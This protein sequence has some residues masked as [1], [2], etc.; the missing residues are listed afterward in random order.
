MTPSWINEVIKKTEEKIISTACRVGDELIFSTYDDGKYVEHN[1]KDLGWWTN[2]FWPG[3]LWLIYRE[4]KD[5][6]I[7]AIAQSAGKKLDSVLYGYD[8]VDHDAGFMWQLSAVTEYNLTGND[9][10]RRKGLVAAALLASRYVGIGEYI[11]A[12]NEEERAG[13]AIVDCMMN[14]PLL[15]WASQ[16]V[17]DSRFT[18]IA[19]K[20]ADTVINKF[21]RPDGSLMNAVVFDT[22]TGEAIGHRVSDEEFLGTTWARGAAW[23]IYGFALS[24]KYTGERRY[25]DT[26]KRL[27]NYFI[28]SLPEDFVPYFYFDFPINDKN[29]RD[30]SAGAIAASGLL[31]LSALADEYEK[32]TYQRAGERILN[33][34]YENYTDWSGKEEAVITH[35]WKPATLI[36]ADYFF[37]EALLRTEGKSGLFE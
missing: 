34:L 4:T 11:R 1:S 16:Q 36:Y 17:K 8:R 12:W 9:E 21:I 26:A 28:A 10:G 31:L 3:L 25:Y 24:Y 37:Y 15:Y 32:N 35:T 18:W 22:E 23:A 13:I 2:G 29:P 27:A 30:A 19:Q 14:L 5:E 7:R 33:S 20:H 6:N